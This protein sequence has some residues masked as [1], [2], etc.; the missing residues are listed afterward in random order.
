VNPEADTAAAWLAEAWAAAEPYEQACL[1]AALGNSE[2]AQVIARELEAEHFAIASHGRI[3]DA[4]AAL[5]GRDEGVDVLTV[6][7]EVERTS[8]W[9]DTRGRDY[10]FL[11]CERTAVAAHVSEYCLQI[12]ELARQRKL[13]RH[14]EIALRDAAEPTLS[15]EARRRLQV[16]VEAARA[17][18]DQQ[19]PSRG[20]ALYDGPALA[21]MEL[22]EPQPI[23]QGL[24][25]RGCSTD[26]VA[27]PKRGKTTLL[28]DIAAA[29]AA[30]R[31][32]C[33]RPTAAS[34][35]LYLSEQSPHSFNPQ[36]A[37]AG[38]GCERRFVTLFHRDALALSWPEIGEHIERA[39][40]DR[41]LELVVIDNLSLWAGIGGEEENDA[42]VALAT[43]HVVERLTGGGLAVVALRHARKGGGTINEAGR[44]SS[45]IAGGFDILA[46]LKGD[47]RPRRRVL[48]TTG[49]IFSAEPLPLTVELDDAGRYRLVGEGSVV[50]RTDARAFL[51][52]FLPEEESDALSE[53]ALLDAA[54]EE[55]LGKSIVQEELRKLVK[56]KTIRRERGVGTVAKNAFGYW[57]CRDAL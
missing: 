41:S 12:T 18:L 42:G 29:V 54:S 37:R 25:Y 43:L 14:L 45:A 7:A 3:F 26:L 52:D 28:L 15:G 53:A 22:D 44:G 10:L 51:L 31:S 34:G 35:V 2:A 5:V 1:G 16:E 33:E 48:E 30:G 57:R 19:T 11:L 8:G 20:L 13:R 49:R 9:N 21:A 32:W 46:L 6:A 36:V 38:L 23:C 17:L 55:Q 24:I 40:H 50:C 56:T 47:L 4:I 39:A 27:E